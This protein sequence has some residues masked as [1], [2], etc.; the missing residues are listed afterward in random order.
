MLQEKRQCKKVI[1]WS[2][3][4]GMDQCVS[5]NL[6]KD[7]LMLDTIW[8]KFEEFCKPQSN[9]VRVR[10]DFLTSFQLGNKSVGEWHTAVQ[11]QVSSKQGQVACKEDGEF[12]GDLQAHQA[13]SK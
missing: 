11:T 9:E 7:E 5:W 8:E 1:A 3:D 12:K 10:F 13:G 6:S 4:F 2:G